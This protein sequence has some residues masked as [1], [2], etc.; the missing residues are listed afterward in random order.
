MSLTFRRQTSCTGDECCA[1]CAGWRL[2]DRH[3]C[4]FG[5]L[6]GCLLSCAQGFL[7]K[8]LDVVQPA[9]PKSLP[10]QV[11][12]FISYF[13]TVL[14]ASRHPSTSEV[15]AIVGLAGRYS[16]SDLLSQRKVAKT[17]Q[18]LNK[19]RRPDCSRAVKD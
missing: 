13:R 5:Q 9:E 16:Q 11:V 19:I 8:R 14:Q 7:R 3:G 17:A 1:A 4:G 6:E 15:G 2:L 18:Q 12:N 10:A